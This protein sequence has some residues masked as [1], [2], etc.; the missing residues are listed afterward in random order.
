VA[1]KTVHCMDFDSLL[2]V[3]R[4][5]VLLT[6]EPHEFS[7]ADGKKLKE[8]LA[9]AEK[10]ASNEKPEE[11]IADK[12][13]FLIFKIASG[14]HFRAGNKRT[15]LVAGL[16]FLLKNGYK[17]DISHQE[18]VSAVDKAGIAAATLDD[19][20]GVI[21]GHTT[22]TKSERGSWESAIKKAVEANRKFLIEAGS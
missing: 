21:E 8:L 6:S 15:A 18:L 9:E 4:E 17:L 11:A 2:A 22:K 16:V 14:Q 12:A 1:K 20:Y 7:P 19:L 10:R 5:V 3:N 13:A